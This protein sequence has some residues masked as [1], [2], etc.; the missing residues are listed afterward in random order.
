MKLTRQQLKKVIKEEKQKLLYERMESDVYK[1][2]VRSLH[3]NGPMS[4][5]ALM[6][7]ILSAFPMLS[8]EEIDRW[9]DELEAGGE[10][11]YNSSTQKYH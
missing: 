7:P 10:I 3:R 5:E 8:D 9:I 1:V 4:H 11:L 2:V 6:Q